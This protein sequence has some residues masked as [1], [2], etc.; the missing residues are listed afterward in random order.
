MRKFAIWATLA[1]ALPAFAAYNW[2]GAVDGYWTNANNWAEGAVPGRIKVPDAAQAG[3]WATNGL[4]TDIAVFGDAL[5]GNAVT[6]INFGSTANR[7][8]SLCAA[9]THPN[10][11]GRFGAPRC[12]VGTPPLPDRIR[13]C[14]SRVISL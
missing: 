3:G 14:T 1:T 11:A 8:K 10:T 6:T 12:R 4:P 2:T 5:T 13:Q 7:R 9:A